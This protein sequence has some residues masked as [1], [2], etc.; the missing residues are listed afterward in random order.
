MEE[1]VKINY[2]SSMDRQPG[3][4]WETNKCGKIEIIGKVDD[5]TGKYYLIKF[6]NT[7]YTK[8]VSGSHFKT[9]EIRDPY[10]KSVYGIGYVGEGNYSIT[11]N[12][13]ES[14]L[15]Y[16]MLARCYSSKYHENCPSY[17]NCEVCE[18]WHNF[19]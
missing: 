19:Q 14:Q 1:R 18:R 2:K 3:A 6:L 12:K 16:N 10:A 17:I 13:R 15:W 7:G 4:V 8:V 9:G 5:G 11:K